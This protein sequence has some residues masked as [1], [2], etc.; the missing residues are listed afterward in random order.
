MC[1]NSSAN[2]TRRSI[3]RA[4]I[5]IIAQQGLDALTAGRLIEQASVSK[6][7]LYHHFRTMAAVETEVLELLT[8]TVLQEVKSSEQPASTEAFFDLVEGQLFKCFSVDNLSIKA[9]FGFLSASVHN[10]ERQLIIRRFMDEIALIRLE[11]LKRVSPHLS[12]MEL[13][14]VVQ[15]IAS[16]QVGLVARYFLAEDL[17]SLRNYWACC[18]K[19]VVVMLEKCERRSRASLQQNEAVGQLTNAE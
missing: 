15:A 3:V 8:Q 19:T 6:G 18:R 2:L 11:Q 14:A 16:L 4:A 17:V 1:S 5:V 7:G 9:L 13:N 10:K 12:H